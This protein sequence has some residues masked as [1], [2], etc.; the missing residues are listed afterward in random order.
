MLTELQREFA[1][2]LRVRGWVVDELV[3]MCCCSERGGG[4]KRSS[5][6]HG[7]CHCAARGRRASRIEI[8]LRE[9]RDHAQFMDYEN[10][11]VGTMCHELAHIVHGNHSADFYKLMENLRTQFDETRLSAGADG[12]GTFAGEG[13]KAD[14]NRH[15]PPADPRTARRLGAAAAE[16]RM[17]RARLMGPPGG[18]YRLGGGGATNS[19]VSSAPSWRHMSPREA[20]AAAAERRRRDDSWC[21][22]EGSVSSAVPP[23]EPTEA[24]SSSALS[25]RER[26]GPKAANTFSSSSANSLPGRKRQRPSSSSSVQGKKK[27][28]A[29]VVV[30]LTSDE[31]GCESSTSPRS[32]SGGTSTSAHGGDS[33]ATEDTEEGDVGWQCPSC[34]LK[35]PPLALACGACLQERPCSFVL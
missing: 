11:I 34:T 13:Q 22:R 15:N 23:Q 14:P 26:G 30:D 31:D 29:A 28:G 12:R 21:H 7:M 33:G 10:Y 20:A 9:P 25:S 32:G 16:K 6:I 2:L 4:V 35:N 8:R 3:E 18:G 5:S 19:A 27:G 1:P 24:D 17:Q